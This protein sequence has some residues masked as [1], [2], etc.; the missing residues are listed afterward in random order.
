[1]KDY[2]KSRYAKLREEILPHLSQETCYG[3]FDPE[4]PTSGH[5]AVIAAI[6]N[7]PRAGRFVSTTMENGDSHWYSRVYDYEQFWYVD[8]TGDQYGFPEVQFT[9]NAPYPNSR[10]REDSELNEET[11]KRA[12]ILA[13][14][15]GYGYW[16]KDE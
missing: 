6:V 9:K 12:K 3:T 2:L 8:L 7:A 4:C 1:M 5:C 16:F 13:E 14:R 15:C 11:R 10:F